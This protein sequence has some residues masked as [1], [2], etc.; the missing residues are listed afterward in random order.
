MVKRIL[1]GLCTNTEV[2]Y[3]ETPKQSN[4]GSMQQQ[5][6][7]RRCDFRMQWNIVNTKLD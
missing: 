2:M 5:Q 3:L 7:S 6:Q 1:L 4:D